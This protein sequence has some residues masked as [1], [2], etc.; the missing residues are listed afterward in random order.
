MDIVVPQGVPGRVSTEEIWH[1]ID[2]EYSEKQ[3]LD[4]SHD[5]FLRELR[6][7]HDKY[8]PLSIQ[9]DWQSPYPA[10]CFDCSQRDRC[11][12]GER[13]EWGLLCWHECPEYQKAQQPS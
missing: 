6:G 2:L 12:R 4:I 3:S 9:E 13:C 7:N 11:S 5:A 1:K 10:R 8:A